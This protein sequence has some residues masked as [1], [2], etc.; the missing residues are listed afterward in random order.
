MFPDLREP[1][2]TRKRVVEE[3]GSD[4][5]S[6]YVEAIGRSE[7]S[8]TCSGMLRYSFGKRRGGGEECCASWSEETRRRRRRRAR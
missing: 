8:S 3:P 4:V 1:F 7:E 5:V 6:E 2:T